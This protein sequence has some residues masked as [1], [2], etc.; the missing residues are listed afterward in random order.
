MREGA[1][2]ARETDPHG[3]PTRLRG[4]QSLI[5]LQSLIK[6][7]PLGGSADRASRSDPGADESQGMIV[8]DTDVL[9]EVLPPKPE[10]RVL[11]WLDQRSDHSLFTTAISHGEILGG[12]PF[13]ADGTGAVRCG[14][15]PLPCSRTTLTG[16]CSTS[17][18]MPPATTR[19][20]P[21]RD[22]PQA[23]G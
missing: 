3:P 17:T 16:V 4:M 10:S 7:A 2:T 22:W 11:A 9:S 21:H 15:Q 1:R 23:V 5:R 18:T 6:E 8:L 20:L 13:L 19:R 14:I 12:I